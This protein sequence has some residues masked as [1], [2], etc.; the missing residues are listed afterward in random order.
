VKAQ[1]SVYPLRQSGLT[2]PFEQFEDMARQ[3]GIRFLAR[4]PIDPQIVQGCDS[5]Q[6]YVGE[7]SVNEAAQAFG[8]VTKY[9]L[10]LENK[11][12]SV[13]VSSN[14]KGAGNMRIE[15]PVV[16]GNL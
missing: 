16:E 10:T 3:L 1:A 8:E 14:D 12:R 5:G 4:V 2:R 13:E 9:M 7:N 6:P 11:S 15:T